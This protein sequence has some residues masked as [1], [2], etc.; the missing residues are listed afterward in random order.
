LPICSLRSLVIQ[1]TLPLNSKLAGTRAS[2]M[3][4]DCLNQIRE[5]YSLYTG[6]EIAEAIKVVRAELTLE[7]QRTELQQE[8]LNKQKKLEELTQNK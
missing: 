1:I 2:S 7:E 8:I 3:N 5:I 4:Q 6:I